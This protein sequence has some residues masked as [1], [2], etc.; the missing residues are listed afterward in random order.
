MAA[1]D[2]GAQA[3]PMKRQAGTGVDGVWQFEQPRARIA[4]KSMR[5][6][7]WEPRYQV[8]LACFLATLTAYIERVGFSIAYTA[9][10]KEAGVDEAQKGT[11][12]S[13]FYWGYAVSQVP[14]GWA[15]QRYGGNAMLSLSFA[16]W[17]LA[18]LLT[19]A[20]A[21]SARAI[22]GARVCVGIAQGFLIPAVHTVLSQ[23]IPPAE[24]ARAVSLTTSGMYLGSAIAMQVLPA[25]ASVLGPGALL[26]GVGCLGLLWLALW[27]V[28]L[29]QVLR[30]TSAGGM[31]QYGGAAGGGKGLAAAKHAPTPWRRMLSHPAVWAIV[32]N[33]FTFHYA[34]YVVMNWMP[35]YFD[36]VLHADLSGLGLVKT[37]PYLVM[38]AASNMGG[39]AGDSLILSRTLRTAGARKAV[40]T[41]GFLAVAGALLLMP[42][43]SSVGGGVRATAAVLG[44]AGFAR[45]GF[46]VNH[47]DIAPRFAGAIM[48]IS[49]TAGTL[50]GVVGVAATGQLLE[51]AGGADRRAGWYAACAVAAAQCVLGSAVF[52]ALARGDR[53][54][55][56]D[57]AA[58]V[59][60]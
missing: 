45:G 44:A 39:W 41:A 25:V 26:R 3:T 28:T 49:N 2:D 38:F 10:A 4:T 30:K 48:G 24:R 59:E 50:A 22:M 18:S 40:N 6:L 27:Q 33:N 53:L 57:V 17:S 47:M 15:A 9:L 11:V 13:A 54:F 55:G 51:R 60:D 23:C 5:R 31:P 43:A 14:G 42:G 58:A 7:R 52:L 29:R 46:S 12:L 19:P 37:L 21:A 16:A 35:T 36:K 8:V 32:I 1:V 34:F 20:S 56:G